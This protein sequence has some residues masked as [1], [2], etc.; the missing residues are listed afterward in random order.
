MYNM[1]P[2]KTV[3]DVK[4]DT[5]IQNGVKDALSALL[6]LKEDVHKKE[7][8]AIKNFVFTK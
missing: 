2:E 7:E 6:N 8:E 4:P 1:E 5:Y 3:K